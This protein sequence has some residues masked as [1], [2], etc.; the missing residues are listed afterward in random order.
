MKL[1]VSHLNGN[2]NVKA[3]LDGFI[4][5]GLLAEFYVSLA[6]FPGTLLDRLGGINQLAEIRRRSF[7]RSLKKYTRSLPLFEAGRLL[8]IKAGA[9]SLIAHEKGMFSV[10]SVAQRI[11]HK[12]ARRIKTLPRKDKYAIYAYEDSALNA[13][14]AAKNAGMPCLYD[15]PIGYWKSAH[16]IFETEKEK[17]PD[18][19]A[20]LTGLNDSPAKLQRKDEELK[21]ADAIFVASSFTA[22]TLKDYSGTLAPVSVIPYGFPPVAGPHEKVYNSFTHNRPLKLLFVGSLSQRKGIAYLFEAVEKFGTKVQLTVVGRKKDVPC[23]ILDKNLSRHT[24]FESLSNN[25]ILQ[26]MREHDVFVFPSLFEGFGLVITEAMSQGTPVITTENTIGPDFITHDENGWLIDAG[27]AQALEAV[28]DKII[29]NPSVIE[30]AGKAAMKTAAERP[31]QVYSNELARAVQ[32]H[33]HNHN[34]TTHEPV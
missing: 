12:V 4:Q 22:K 32:T 19:A 6:V 3:A 23:A 2:A 27:S 33:F 20:T 29:S 14:R 30:K 34:K 26:L 8:A 5:A 18:W 31:W 17:L 1:I 11:D 9:V 7:D 21:L 15:L 25:E 13:F 28:L 10:D 16:K 24:W